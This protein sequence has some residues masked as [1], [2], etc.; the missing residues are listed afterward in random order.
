MLYVPGM[1]S[2][3]TIEYLMKDTKKMLGTESFRFL[4]A[5]V[6]SLQTLI[7]QLVGHHF[8]KSEKISQI[9]L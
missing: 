8:S 7:K 5:V 9:A 4:E 1:F 2:H 3:R 6:M